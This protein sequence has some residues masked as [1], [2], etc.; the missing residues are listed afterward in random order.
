MGSWIIKKGQ[1]GILIPPF[2]LKMMAERVINLANNEQ[3]KNK[4]MQACLK[5]AKEFEIN[6]VG[7]KWMEFFNPL[8]NKKDTLPF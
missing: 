7:R 5:N 8:L 2:D 1:S 4:L 6:N 3:H